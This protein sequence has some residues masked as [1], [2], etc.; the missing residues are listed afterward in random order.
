MRRGADDGAAVPRALPV[1]PV[2]PP[3]VA[4]APATTPT[5]YDAPPSSDAPARE[6]LHDASP[7]LGGIGLAMTGL[8]FSPR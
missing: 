7:K 1:S 2:P 6:P 4:A 3:A 8:G 5:I